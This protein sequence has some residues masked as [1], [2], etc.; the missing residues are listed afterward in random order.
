MSHG[1]DNPCKEQCGCPDCMPELPDVG[2]LIGICKLID[3]TAAAMIQS[4]KEAKALGYRGTFKRWNELV[5]ERML[6]AS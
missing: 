6:S 1:P 2:D 5:Q 4:Y 3:S